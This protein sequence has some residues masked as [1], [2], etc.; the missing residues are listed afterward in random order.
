MKLTIHLSLVLRLITC[1]LYLCS[2]YTLLWSGDRAQGQLF[3][4]S[5]PLS[6]VR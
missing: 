4:Y 2:L 6:I 3:L 5:F 1:G